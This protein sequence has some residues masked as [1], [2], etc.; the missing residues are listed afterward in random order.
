MRKNKTSSKNALKVSMISICVG[1]A[2]GAYAQNTSVTNSN[3]QGTEGQST[4]DKITQQ[5]GSLAQQA[6]SAITGALSG[7]SGTTTSSG[8]GSSGVTGNTG[9]TI[10]S[11]TV[12]ATTAQSG[13]TPVIE[14]YTPQQLDEA[15]CDRGVW[16]KLVAEY[17]AKAA[18]SIAANTEQYTRQL[19]KGT[20]PIS[21]MASCFNQAANIIN[22]ATAI[23]TTITKLLSG[24]GFDSNKL[25][26]YGKDLLTKYACSLVDSY[27]A[28]TGIS[29]TLNGVNNL[30]NT[31]LGTNVGV[32][33]VNTNVGNILQG[34]GYQQGQG[35]AQQVTGGQVA[36]SVNNA[37]GLK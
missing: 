29:S 28:S 30:P 7:N 31:V 32:G 21:S 18:T 26:D 37:L 22:S 33:G 12:A 36:N 25:M 3:T 15:G 5:A 20:P 14:E 16:A 2:I 19:V 10:N 11:G 27:V 34:G 17:Q 23:Y 35:S 6:G 4:L 8:V 9:S 13:I 24:G 1:T